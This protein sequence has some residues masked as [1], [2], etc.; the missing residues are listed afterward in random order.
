M[1]LIKLNFNGPNAATDSGYVA[2]SPISSEK[3]YGPVTKHVRCH[4]SST[5]ER[6]SGGG[7]IANASAILALPAV[8]AAL[9]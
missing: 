5:F 8:E 9:R 3:F 1:T 2:V 7:A 6:H 4:S